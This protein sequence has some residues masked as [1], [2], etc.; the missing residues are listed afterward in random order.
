MKLKGLIAATHT[1]F[2]S[3]G[4]LNLDVVEKQANHLLKNKITAAFINGTTGECHSLTFKERLQLTQQWIKSTKG[5]DLKVVVHIGSNCIA[6]SCALA[7]EAEKLGVYA[8]A[9]MAPSYFKP[10]SLDDLI[11][12][13]AKIASAAPSTPFYFYDIPILTGVCFSMPEFLKRAP[14]KIPN[15][16][17]IKFTNSDLMSYQLCLRACNWKFDIPYGTDEWLLA[18][19][20]LGGEGAVGSS[21][22]FAAPLYHRLIN[23]FFAED[24]EKAQTEQFHSVE[25]IKLLSSYGYLSA[26]KALMGMLGIKV[27]NPRLPIPP[28]TSGQIKQLRTDLEQLGFF[29]WIK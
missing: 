21:Y 14:E 10:V 13:C 18:A 12:W 1:P 5:T 7:A 2:D 3:D 24:L 6:D 26:S 22:N 29:N 20:A 9:A 4:A 17:G 25:L 11:G 19:L 8:I 15:L 23:A 28:L 16:V 27:G